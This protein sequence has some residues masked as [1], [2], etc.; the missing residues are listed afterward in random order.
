MVK[1]SQHLD[2]T[3]GVSFLVWVSRT[4]RSGVGEVFW[5]GCFNILMCS[6]V[7]QL[8][9]L[10]LEL[11]S[12]V[13][14]INT[15]HNVSSF[16]CHDCSFS[17]WQKLFH[18]PKKSICSQKVSIFNMSDTSRMW[19]LTLPAASATHRAVHDHMCFS[20][21]VTDDQW[22]CVTTIRSAMDDTWKITNIDSC[23]SK[24]P[25]SFAVGEHMYSQPWN[26]NC[27]HNRWEPNLL[28]FVL[29]HS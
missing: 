21:A 9:E 4:H 22:H 2:M 8:T 20:T 13:G 18:C 15:I 19:T 26:L 12:L 14:S 25:F 5:F 6:T 16:K 27:Y 29:K 17:R 3:D 24:R 28:P 11:A 1:E 7:S 23:I 10:R